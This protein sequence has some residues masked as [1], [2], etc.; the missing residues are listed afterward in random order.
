[1]TILAEH[2]PIGTFTAKLI[3]PYDMGT[4]ALHK[5]LS[6]LILKDLVFKGI[7]KNYSILDPF[8]TEWIRMVSKD[9]GQFS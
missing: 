7:D 1:M 2:G 5:A 3:Q 8:L 6:N 4:P 9:E